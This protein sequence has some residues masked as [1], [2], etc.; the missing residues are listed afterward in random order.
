MAKK[1]KNIKKNI[2]LSA[3]ERRIAAAKKSRSR[4]S[5]SSS[6]GQQAMPPPK[7]K[8]KAAK[9][10]ALRG[11]HKTVAGRKLAKHTGRQLVKQPSKQLVKQKGRKVVKP[12]PP[13]GKAIDLFRKKFPPGKGGGPRSGWA[14]IAAAIAGATVAQ[15]SSKKAGHEPGLGGSAGAEE[16]FVPQGRWKHPVSSASKA[17]KSRDK[18]TKSRL[19]ASKARKSRDAGTKRRLAASKKKVRDPEAF[20]SRKPGAKKKRYRTGLERSP[21]AFA[22]RKPGAGA[23]HPA[24]RKTTKTTRKPPKHRAY[25]IG[26]GTMSEPYLEARNLPKKKKKKAKKTSNKNSR[27]NGMY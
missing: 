14:Y 18:G 1:K 12:P 8:K 23:K 27:R 4:P 2:E 25:E 7:T 22:S 26:A 9:K 17:R 15:L 3:A 19:A 16:D 13:K 5:K 24:L 10:K 11:Q 20:A 21:E 6:K